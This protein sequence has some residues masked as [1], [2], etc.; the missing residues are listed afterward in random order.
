MVSSSAL[1]IARGIAI[2]PEVLLLD[3][4]CSALDPI[5]TGRIEGLITELKQGLH[6]GDRDPTTCSRR[7]VAPIIQRLCTGEVD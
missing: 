4:P 5:S 7:H 6:R 2:R 3:E 1:C